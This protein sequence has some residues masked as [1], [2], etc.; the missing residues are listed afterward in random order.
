[1]ENLDFPN[2][3]TFSGAFKFLNLS[4]FRHCEWGIISIKQHANDVVVSSLRGTKQSSL[5]INVL[6]ILDGVFPDCFVVPANSVY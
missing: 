5:L 1:M 6:P 3:V 2:V 4:R